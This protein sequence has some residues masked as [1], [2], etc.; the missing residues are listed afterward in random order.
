[1]EIQLSCIPFLWYNKLS[2]NQTIEIL[3]GVAGGLFLMHLR[4]D[5]QAHHK[6]C[7]FGRVAEERSDT[8]EEES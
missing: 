2:I 3:Q 1:M 6:W 7:V 4:P 5:F 8:N